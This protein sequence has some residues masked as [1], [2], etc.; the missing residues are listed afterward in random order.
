MPM[1]GLRKTE[2][3]EGAIVRFLQSLSRTGN[4]GLSC[5]AAGL[6]RKHVGGLLLA[7]SDFADAYA[8]AMEDAQDLLYAEARRRAVTGIL[9][10]AGGQAKSNNGGRVRKYSDPLLMMLMRQSGPVATRAAAGKPEADDLGAILRS[11]VRD[12]DPSVMQ[13]PS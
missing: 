2:A 10:G 7:D 13:H 1:T 5:R 8:Q 3:K 4:V 11:I 12:E 6:A 9:I